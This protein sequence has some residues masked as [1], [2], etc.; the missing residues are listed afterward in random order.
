MLHQLHQ[1]YLLLGGPE[2]AR[3]TTVRQARGRWVTRRRRLRGLL[4]APVWRLPMGVHHA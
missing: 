1:T 3:T 4:R 2:P